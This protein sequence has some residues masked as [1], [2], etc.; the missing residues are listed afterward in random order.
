MINNFELIRSLLQF[1]SDD[2]YYHLQILQRKK[3]HPHLKIKNKH[4][5]HV[6]KDYYITSLDHFDRIQDEVLNLCTIFF[7][8]AYINLNVRSFK[9]TSLKGLTILAVNIMNGNYKANRS[10]FNSAS[11][12]CK[13]EDEELWILDFDYIPKSADWQLDIK[14]QLYGCKPVMVDKVK[15]FIPTKNGVHVITTP[16]DRSIFNIR[17]PDVQIHKNNPT[18][19]ACY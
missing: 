2:H 14:G 11:G 8:R 17:Y 13:S 4:S 5:A 16:F 7:A 9:N 1:K 3:D 18:L 19:L 15:T 12:Q 10:L 6:I